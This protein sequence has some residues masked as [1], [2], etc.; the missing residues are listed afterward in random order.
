MDLYNSL[1]KETRELTD[2]LP[3]RVWD[4]DPTAAWPDTGSSELVL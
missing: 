4:Y 3:A 2:R 1:I